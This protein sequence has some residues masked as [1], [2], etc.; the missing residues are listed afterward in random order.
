MSTDG[1]EVA[2]YDSIPQPLPLSLTK[3][4][5]LLKIKDGNSFVVRKLIIE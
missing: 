2:R 3:G 4:L 5:Y 1:R